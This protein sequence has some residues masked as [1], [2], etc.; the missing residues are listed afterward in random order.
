MGK[1]R[2]H[3]N[4]KP[5]DPRRYLRTRD[6]G[7]GLL[8]TTFTPSSFHNR[9]TWSRRDPQDSK[10][11]LKVGLEVEETGEWTGGQVTET[12]QR[13]TTIEGH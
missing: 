8:G 2:R 9:Q 7:R 1:K 11:P 5:Q 4:S 6:E 12:F 10:S 13:I 3:W